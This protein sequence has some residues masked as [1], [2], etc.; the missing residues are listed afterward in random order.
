MKLIKGKYVVNLEANIEH[1][2][3][4]RL[5]GKNVFVHALFSLLF[6]VSMLKIK[7]SLFVSITRL[8]S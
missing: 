6:L 2:P 5:S 3:S 4:Q 1:S 7:T 8:I